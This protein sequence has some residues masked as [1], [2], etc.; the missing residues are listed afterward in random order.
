VV[1]LTDHGEFDS[2]LKEVNKALKASSDGNDE[3]SWRLRVLKARILVSQKKYRETLLVLANDLPPEFATT[4]IGAQRKI[5]MGVAHRC[6]QQ[7]AE[8]EKD[9]DEVEAI[10]ENLPPSYKCQFLITRGALRGDEKRYTESGMDYRKALA[11][12]RKNNLP[13]MESSALTDLGWLATNEERFDAAVDI[14]R[15]ALKLSESLQARGYS[16][17]ILGNIAW[18]YF[19]LGDFASALEYYNR[20]AKASVESGLTGNTDYWFTGVANS[21]I[22][23][24]D[25]TAA[26]KIAHDTLKSARDLHNAQ[27]VVESLN[28]LTEATL[29]T[30]RVAEAERYNQEAL[31]WERKGDDHFGT[32]QSLLLAGRIRLSKRDFPGAQDYLNQALSYPGAE[33]PL[34]WQ[35]QAALAELKDRQGLTSAADRGFRAAI[36]RIEAARSSIEHEE[37]RISFLSTGM[38]IYGDYIDFLIRHGRS[39]EALAQ[40]ELSRARTLSEGLA[41]TSQTLRLTARDIRPQEVAR[42]LGQPLLFYWV[43]MQHSYLWVITPLRTAYFEI[44]KLLEIEPIVKSYRS[45]LRDLHDPRDSGSAVGQQLYN[46]LVG[47]AKKLIPKGSR[48]ILLPDHSLSALNFE[49]L[50]VPEPQPHFWIEDVTLTTAS[51]LTLLASSAARPAAKEKSLLL[52]GNTVPVDSFPA[53]PQAPDEMK[54]VQNYFPN[55]QR[56]ILEG[57]Q[58]TPAAYLNSNP[59]RFAYLHFVTHGTASITRPLESAV[60]LSKDGESYKL[61]ARDIVKHPLTA[62]LVTI[63]ACEGAGRTAYSGEG[64]IGLS[65]AFLRAGAH[66]VIGALW[67]VNDSAAPQLMDS[68]YSELRRG[69][70]TASALRTAKL[71]LLHTKDSQSVFRKPYYWAPFQLY[72]GS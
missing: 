16:A 27:T 13:L 60:I 35:A 50:I 54:R 21:Y 69:Q 9:F 40:A 46:L 34:K 61:Y 59:E 5:Y 12:A 67:E 24:H 33:T 10:T 58:A 15:A 52:V 8:A 53:L 25:Y 64:L 14:N 6:G 48:A 41:S 39:E 36:E 22:A 1:K 42:K 30:S 72:A 57:Q 32:S 7:F 20:G 38:E 3:L 65:W 70:D 37:L 23:L 68:F 43:G 4:S 51:S 45:T 17:T 2:A 62:Q 66:N 44:P 31:D 29:K 56:T 26:E 63:S 55:S 49:T 28:I 19:E 18:S 11:L 47:P 71:S